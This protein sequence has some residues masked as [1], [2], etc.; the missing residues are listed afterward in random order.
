MEYKFI[1]LK[2]LRRVKF[3]GIPVG[4]EVSQEK[5]DYDIRGIEVLKELEKNKKAS[6]KDIEQFRTL[7]ASTYRAQAEAFMTHGLITEVQAVDLESI[8]L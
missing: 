4:W 5:I 8:K 2:I 3:L 7:M 1:T 6:Q